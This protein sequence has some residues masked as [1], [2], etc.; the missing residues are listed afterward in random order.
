METLATHVGGAAIMGINANMNKMTKTSL[1][2][3][4]KP[5][6]YN[7]LAANRQSSFIGSFELHFISTCWNPS[8]LPGEERSELS[9]VAYAAVL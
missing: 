5:G 2:A 1:Q 9:R 6:W 8:S 4:K 3:Q 7:A